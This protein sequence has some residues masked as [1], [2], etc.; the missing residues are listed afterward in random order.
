VIEFTI[1][2]G[3]WR[4]DN[5]E[6][7]SKYV[8][9]FKTSKYKGMMDRLNKELKKVNIEWFKFRAEFRTIIVSSLEEFWILQFIT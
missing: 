4:E 6:N 1:P 9:M 7:T 3:R 5:Y 2:F 8:N